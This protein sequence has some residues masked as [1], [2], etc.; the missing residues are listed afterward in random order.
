MSR[1][2]GNQSMAIESKIQWCHS[3]FNPWLG[4]TK[5]S[6][7]CANCYAEKNRAVK[8]FGVR[9]GKGSARRRTSE[10]YWEDPMRWNLKAK[11]LGVQHRVFCGSLCDWADGE[12]SE[13]W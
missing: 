4:C 10:T 12:V 11:R 6:P 8:A 13:E 7:G 9:W 2:N 5:V 3:T 1:W